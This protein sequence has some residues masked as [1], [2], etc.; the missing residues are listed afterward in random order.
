[1]DI[2]SSG[3]TLETDLGQIDF[4][5]IKLEPYEEQECVEESKSLVRD[6]INREGKIWDQESCVRYEDD[7]E[8]KV[9]EFEAVVVKREIDFLLKG[10]KLLL[11][12]FLKLIKRSTW[13]MQALKIL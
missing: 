5:K 4:P 7:G 9:E 11:I 8:P 1:M 3:V 6:F 12:N 13:T 2:G 10:M